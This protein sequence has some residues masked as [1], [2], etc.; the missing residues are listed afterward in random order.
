[1][2]FLITWVAHFFQG[3]WISLHG[4]D[5]GELVFLVK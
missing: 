2:K 4:L 3:E 5:V 1:M